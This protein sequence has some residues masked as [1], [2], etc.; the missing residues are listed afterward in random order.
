MNLLVAAVGIIGFSIAANA[1]QN[2]NTTFLGQ[3]NPGAAAY[4]NIWGWTSPAGT[5]YAILGGVDGTFFIDITNAANPIV[6]YTV[7]GNNSI[8]REIQVW[9]H[10]AYVV[11]EWLGEPDSAKMGAQIIDLSPLPDSVRLVRHFRSPAGPDAYFV[12]GH[13]VHIR[14]GFL[15]INGGTVRGTAIFDLA[16]PENPVYRGLYRPLESGPAPYTHDCYVRN[17]TLYACDIIN[18]RVDIVDVR[19]K[20]KPVRIARI[21]YP[22][23][24]SWWP[25]NAALSQDG[26]YLLV[27]D[28]NVGTPGFLSIWDLMKFRQGQ[29]NI[30]RAATYRSTFGGLIH[31]VYVKDD[32]AIMSYYND[33]VHIVDISDPTDP[34]FVGNYDNEPMTGA[35]FSGAWGVYPFFASGKIIIS[36]I[37]DGLFVFN[38]NGVHAGRIRGTVRDLQSGQSVPFA[39]INLQSSKI[40]YSDK[41]GR[42][43]MGALAGSYTVRLDAAGYYDTVFT[44]NLVSGVIQPRD[45]WIRKIPTVPPAPPTVYALRQNY[46]NPF[47]PVTSITFDLPADSRIRILVY[48]L[49][50][51]RVTTLADGTFPKGEGMVQWAGT[52][53]RGL[54]VAS[55]VYLYRLEAT[56]IASGEK[57]SE[58]RR[59]IV[60]R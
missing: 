41:D 14:D 29:G 58:T 49:L 34:V 20:T 12:G 40:R 30:E 7:P 24:G 51:Q 19:D 10:Y 42:Y 18:G 31:N 16:D 38:H 43:S 35:G 22:D 57:Y 60:L 21:Q 28:E 1:Q 25:H 55:G 6:R 53:E 44:V 9:D 11:V 33:G 23:V 45:L 48:N 4:S 36:D 39:Q 47:N 59:M 2:L 46:P 17:D 27:T 26:S 5:E 3:L 37:E 15:Y 56:K 52:D 50:G 8:W 54:D 32:L 13:S